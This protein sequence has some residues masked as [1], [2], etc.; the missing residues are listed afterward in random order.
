MSADNFTPGPWK[1]RT[2]DGSLGSIDGAGDVMVAQAQ[3]VNVADRNA[4]SPQRKANTR[5][6][7]AAP[8]LL[9]RLRDALEFIEDQEDVND[10]P[11]G[12]P[13]ANRAMQL[14]ESIRTTLSK[15]TGSAS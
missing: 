3:E 8:E 11:D 1:V 9:D 5:L 10:G 12:Q 7:A 2:L 13:V 15:A 4:G 14:A 6:I